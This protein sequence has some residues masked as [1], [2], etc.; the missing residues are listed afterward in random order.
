MRLRTQLGLRYLLTLIGAAGRP[1]AAIDLAFDGDE[2][3]PRR[4]RRRPLLD[5]RAKAELKARVAELDDQLEDARTLGDGDKVATLEEERDAVV[6]ELARALGLGG[7]ARRASGVAERTRVAVTLAIKRAIAAVTKELPAVGEH[8]R[9]CV[10]T[11]AT[12]S[13]DPDPATTLKCAVAA[14]R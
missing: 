11:G 7:R 2:R 3:A 12:C 9:R 10:R 4:R 1:I 14:A 8:L 6:R 5:S 13:Y